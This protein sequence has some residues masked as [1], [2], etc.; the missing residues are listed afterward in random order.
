M[1]LKLAYINRVKIGSLSKYRQLI[2]FERSPFFLIDGFY[3]DQ[4]CGNLL[5]KQRGLELST[6]RHKL[7]YYVNRY[8]VFHGPF[9]DVEKYTRNTNRCREALYIYTNIKPRFLV[10]I[11]FKKIKG[12]FHSFSTPCTNSGHSMAIKW[13]RGGNKAFRPRIKY[14]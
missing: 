2:K 1:Q 3:W 4:T 14:C 13:V 10:S 8:G 7:L 9:P 6:N 5:R 12:G 11:L